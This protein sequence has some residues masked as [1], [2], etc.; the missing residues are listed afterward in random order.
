MRFIGLTLASALITGSVSAC[1]TAPAPNPRNPYASEAVDC[2]SAATLLRRGTAPTPVM[3]PPLWRVRACPERAAELLAA[4]LDSSRQIADTSEL[5]RR[6][7]LAQ[8]VHDARITRVALLVAD[9][10]AAQPVAR[11]AAVRILV[12]MKSPGQRL[13]IQSIVAGPSCMPPLCYSTYEGHFFG[14]DPYS[15]DSASVWPVVGRVMEDT[16]A[17]RIDSA[18]SSVAA[19][20]TTVAVVRKACE[21]AMQFPMASRLKALLARRAT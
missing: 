17:E 12:W 18:L 14:P 15:M 2:R 13:S 10:E 8:Y 19:R 5:D 11:V 21:V 7:W 6:T 3:A 20:P 1:R 16:Y 9:D 4:L